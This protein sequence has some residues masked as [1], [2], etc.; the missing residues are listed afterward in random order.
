MGKIKQIDR[1]E[2]LDYIS[3]G[4]EVFSLKKVVL[5]TTINELVGCEAFVT[6]ID[7]A[8]DI[9]GVPEETEEEP[10]PVNEA[11][12]IL[13]VEKEKKYPAKKSAKGK[14]IDTGKICAL[15]KGNW[16]ISEIAAEMGCSEQTVYNHLHACGMK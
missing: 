15:R 16:P 6:I 5:D 4:E 1:N 7:E 13:P 11:E 10:E 3:Q 14:K 2:L 12:K 8:A 9:G